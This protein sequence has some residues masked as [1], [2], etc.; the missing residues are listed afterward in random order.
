MLLLGATL[1]GLSACNSPG[2]DHTGIDDR[3]PSDSIEP[4]AGRCTDYREGFKN[5]Y[6]G[7]LHTHTS[8]SLDSYFFNALT[9]PR[10]SHRFAKGIGPISLPAQGSQDVFTPAREINIDRPLDFNAVTDHAEFLGG[11]IA[12]C[13]QSA[14]T[15][16]QCDERIGQG[17]RDNIRDIAAGNTPFQTQLLQSLIADSPTSLAAWQETKTINDEEYEPC[18]FTTFHGYEFTSNELSQ[19]F[20]RNVIFKGNSDETP[21]DVFPA[22]S[23]TTALSPENG[24]DDWDLF[25]HLQSNCKDRADCDVLT[26]PHNANRSDGRMFLAADETSGKT[27]NGALNGAPLGRKT[28]Q[29]DIYFPMTEADA[30][31]RRSLDRSYEITQHKGQSECAVGLEGNYL[32]NDEGYD[33]GCDFEVDNSACR[34]EADDPPACAHFCTGAPTDP[35]FCGLRD[36]GQNVIPVCAFSGPDGSSRPASGGDNTGNCRSPLDFYRNAMAEG[37]KIK[38]ALGI[39]P[40]RTNITASLDTHSGDSGNAQET[41]FVGHGGVIDDDPREQLGFWGCDNEADGEDPADL[42]NCTNRTFVDFARPLNPGG[43]A[44]VWAAENTRNDIWDSIHSGETWGTSGT[45]IRVRSIASWQPLPA[46]ICSRLSSGEDLVGTGAVTDAAAMGGDLPAATSQEGPYIAVWAEQDPD[47]IPLQQIDLVKGFINAS[48][49]PKIL[50]INNLVRTASPVSPPRFNDCAVAT[51]NHPESLCAIWQDSDFD[52]SK[53]AYYYP[54]VR[55]IKSCRWSTHVCREA[56]A[57]CSQLDASNGIFPENSGLQGYE[58]CCQ[59]EENNGVFSGQDRFE[60]I[61]ERAWGSPIWYE[62]ENT[63]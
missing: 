48:N 63:P 15:Q 49:E 14:Q 33:P 50:V 11:F 51:D 36:P 39:N 53:D 55:E 23:P 6:F 59:I 41:P 8:Y 27:I 28:P 30:E 42:N 22:V 7:D 21:T 32:A 62:T 2:L 24:N 5:S 58:G 34:G 12:T 16:Q 1:A 57:D 13:D 56:Q 25:D 44:G 31:L 10:K 60:A 61:E 40:Y 9:D 38:E 3:T 20:H 43:L 46:G 35:T 17:I 29:T 45:R 37:L 4:V 26:I 52:A 19:M 47:G 54:R 18:D